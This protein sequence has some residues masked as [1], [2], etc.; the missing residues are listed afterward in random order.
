MSEE[1][2][3]AYLHKY[4]TY[5]KD[6]T[7]TR[8]DRKNSNG[9][10][11]K[12]GY[13]IIKIKTKQYKAHRLVF[14]YFNGRFPVKEIDHI[15]RIRCDNRIENLR[16]ATRAENNRNKSW[17]PNKDT[18]EIGIY[19]D[20]TKGLKARYAFGF[21]GKRYR[22]RSIQEAKEWREKLWNGLKN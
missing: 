16:E 18:G 9:R 10:K 8:S 15:N 19:L 22:F 21:G 5:H 4:F 7:F 14:A 6:G 2:L 20:K 3:I 11:D 13:V 1:E 12:Q 17:E